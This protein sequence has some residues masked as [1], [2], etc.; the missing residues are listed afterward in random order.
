MRTIILYVKSLDHLIEYRPL[1]LRSVV[2]AILISHGVREY[3]RMVSFIAEKKSSIVVLGSRVKRVYPDEQSLQGI[4]NK[5]VKHLRITPPKGRKVHPGIFIRKG[6][7][8]T[9]LK[10]C[11]SSVNTY[12]EEGGMSTIPKLGRSFTAV[13]PFIYSFTS[14]EKNMLRRYG[15]KPLKI[16]LNRFYPDQIVVILNFIGDI[17]W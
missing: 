6:D 7:F 17:T 16:N 15:Y 10:E 9:L 3:C 12:I 11:K 4:F 1:F 5:I 2:Y 8:K 13:I 14:S